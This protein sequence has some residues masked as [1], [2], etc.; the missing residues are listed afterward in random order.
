M[1]DIDLEALAA[2]YQHRTASPESAERAGD[3]ADAAD[4]GPGSVTIDVGGGRGAHSGVFAGRGGLAIV[5]DRS[6][7]MVDL[8]NSVPGVSAV[9]GEASRLPVGNGCADLVYFHLSIHY[10]DWRGLLDEAMRVCR[11]G[12]MVWVWTFDKAQV[13]SSFLAR[14]FPS[15]APIDEARF[16]EP[17]AIAARLSES[18]YGDVSL[19][20]S[21]ETVTRTAGNWRAAVEAG[22]VSTL[23]MLPPGELAD[24]LERF[25]AEHPDPSEKIVYHLAYRSVSGSRP[26]PGLC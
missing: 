14:W 2:G 11:P 16:P 25:T 9:V 12:G 7:A 10:R 1:A 8:A 13:R 17:E 5:I 22:F 21:G 19:T 15:V 6:T 4:L 3:A 24:G 18:G 20:E 23:Q 26:S